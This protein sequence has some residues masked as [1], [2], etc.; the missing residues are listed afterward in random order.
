MTAGFLILLLAVLL[1]ATMAAAWL[2]AIRTGRSGWIDAIW[3]FAVGAG[4]VAAAFLPL[5]GDASWTVRQWVVAALAGF[6]S[7]RLGL[8]IL[9]RTAGGGD[10]PRYAQLRAE[11]GTNFRRRLFWFLQI[12][13]A[14]AFLLVMAI[15]AAARNPAASLGP[16]DWLGIA[17][18]IIAVAGEAI[19]DRQ[20]TAF[21]ADRA[22]KGRVCD[23][24]LWSLTRHPNY[25]FEW[26]GWVAYPIIAIDLTN[27]YPWGWAALAGPIFM[28]WLLVHVSGIPPLEAHML[29]SRGEKFR[30]YQRR[31]NAFWPGPRRRPTESTS[32]GKKV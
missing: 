24:G 13:A 6:W 11:W 5:E 19:A 27:D 29:R 20:L 30:E 9:A 12:Q 31:V 17:V 23:Q 4:G 10:D 22:N 14:A 26:L 8:H 7:L 3:S 2:A 1:S 18:L 28:Y 15:F 32:K 25:F 21:R 16:G